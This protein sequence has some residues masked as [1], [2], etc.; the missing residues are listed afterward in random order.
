MLYGS[1]LGTAEELAARVAD[2]AEVNG[3]ATRLAPLDDFVGQLPQFYGVW[4]FSKNKQAAKD[5]LLYI[6]QKEAVALAETTPR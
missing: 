1:N 5:L 3:F 4:S 2:L 6:S